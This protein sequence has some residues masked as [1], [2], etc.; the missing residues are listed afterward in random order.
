MSLYGLWAGYGAAPLSVSGLAT[1]GVGGHGMPG[2]GAG[3]MSPDEFRE[4]AMRFIEAGMQPDG[5]VRP[6]RVAMA[7]MDMGE[8]DHGGAEAAHDEAV[9]HVDGDEHPPEEHAAVEPMAG[10][11]EDAGHA[12]ME[13]AGHDEVAD[14]HADDGDVHGPEPVDVY[15]IAKRYYY[16]PSILR[17]ER[18]VP[19]NFQIMAMDTGHG[20]SL[21]SGMGI[22]VGG[23][24]MRVPAGQIAEME[25]TFTRSGE[26]LIF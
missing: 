17:L 12:A 11:E 1:E 4:I 22:S 18:D 26:F 7:A 13:E 5:S 24:M 2:M 16:E 19:Y 8:A 23:H 20:A 9:A 10:M 14:D 3:S 25:M 15:M 6:V 21:V